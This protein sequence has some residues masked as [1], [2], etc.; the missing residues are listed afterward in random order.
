MKKFG[1]NPRFEMWN[2]AAIRIVLRISGFEFGSNFVIL[3]S[4][5]LRRLIRVWALSLFLSGCSTHQASLNSSVTDLNRRPANP[6][7]IAKSQPVVLLFVRTDCPVSNRYAPEIERLYRAY[8]RHHINF[9]LVYPDADTTT[10]DILKH[11]RDYSLDVPALRDPTHELVRAASATATPEAAVFVP[12]SPPVLAYRGRIDDRMADFGK[13]RP[14]A[15]ERDL[16]NVLEG[17]A[18]GKKMAPRT[19]KAVGCYIT[20]R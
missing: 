15:R 5:L 12:G 16:E 10:S 3:H 19:T 20:E 9:W 8:A 7:V 1:I 17:I 18:A 11:Q 6:L 13:E 14:E 4:N 2:A